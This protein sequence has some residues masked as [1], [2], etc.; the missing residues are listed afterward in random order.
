MSIFGAASGL[1]TDVYSFAATKFLTGLGVGGYYVVYS[2]YLI[3]FLTPSWRT[4]CG[5][6]SLWFLGELILTLFA[7]FI[8]SWRILTLATSLPGL[9]IFLTYP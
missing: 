4:I 7:Y 8:P 6:V 2:I 3:E 1:V 9:L 5:C